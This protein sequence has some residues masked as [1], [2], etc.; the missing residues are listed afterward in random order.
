M[1]RICMHC[2]K[3][4]DGNYNALVC[5]NCRSAPL[6]LTCDACG[7]KF[8]LKGQEKIKYLSGKSKEKRHYCSKKC[9]SG[10]YKYCDICKTETFH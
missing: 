5:H 8:E 10:G 7:K 6:F 9:G 4:F 2:H 3:E 1:K